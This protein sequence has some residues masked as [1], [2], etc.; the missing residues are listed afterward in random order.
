MRMLCYYWPLS[1]LPTFDYALVGG[2]SGGRWPRRKL[3]SGAPVVS[4][5][6]LCA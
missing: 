1:L 3:R 4:A 2:G 6:L 5:R